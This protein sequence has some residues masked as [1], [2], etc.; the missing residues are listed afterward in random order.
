MEAFQPV[1]PPLSKRVLA[2]ALF[3]GGLIV[4][5]LA[6]VFA[7]MQWQQ[8]NSQQDSLAQLNRAQEV[9]GSLRS[10]EEKPR[11]L[12]VVKALPSLAPAANKIVPVPTLKPEVDANLKQAA[13]TGVF[14]DDSSPSPE[15]AANEIAKKIDLVYAEVPRNTLTDLL[16]DAK[17]LVSEGNYSAGTMVDLNKQIEASKKSDSFHVLDSQND[18]GIHVNQPIIVFKGIRDPSTGQNLG[19][20]L[21]LTP[22]QNDDQGLHILVEAQRT[23]REGREGSGSLAPLVEQSFQQ[24]FIIPHHS[25]AYL[26]GL[27][28]HRA[29]EDAERQ[30]L[31]NSGIF[32]V[33]SSTSYQ[34]GSSE[35]VIFLEVR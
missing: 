1:A 13:T 14:N 28:P 29:L 18:Q 3:Q 23:L 27:L 20:T 25:G 17:T 7:F 33:F 19:L 15:A 6:L 22:E 34:Q 12:P 26:A 16:N 30:L 32:K 5:I 31:G 4:I 9:H 11:A 35:F 10:L 21:Q 8:K 24:D 2:S